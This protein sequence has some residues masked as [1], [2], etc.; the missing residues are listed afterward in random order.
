MPVSTDGLSGTLQ[1][2]AR[3][4]WLKALGLQSPPESLEIDNVSHRLIEVFKH[5]SW[6]ATALYE[7]CDGAL[8]VV[9]LHRQEGLFGIPMTW[10]GRWTARNER[11]LLEHLAGLRGIPTL[12][13]PVHAG[14]R[15]FPNAVAR[16]FIAGHPLGDREAV[17]DRF[18]EELS[19]LLQKMH[20]RRTVYVDLHKRENIIV[21]QSGE[22]CLIDFQISLTWPKGLQGPIFRLMKRSNNITSSST[23]QRC[24]PD[25]CG[26][27]FD[28]ASEA[29]PGDQ[30]P[31]ESCAAISRVP[32][33]LLVRLGMRSGKGRVKRKSSQNTPLVI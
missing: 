31:P 9:K 7:G 2:R 11:R 8:R 17:S 29:R 3:P 6:A 19:L 13:G 1:V 16:E 24:R 4:R 26:Y 5:D 22:P 23:E 10:L 28:R 15:V 18:F 27:G 21:N 25:Q 12:A 30:A 33:A 14:G 20:Q 32:P